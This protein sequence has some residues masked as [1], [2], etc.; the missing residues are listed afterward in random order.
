[1]FLCSY[2]LLIGQSKSALSA[3]P[4]AIGDLDC[5]RPVGPIILNP[6]EQAP[7]GES[8]WLFID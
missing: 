3:H 1:M 8:L 5:N 7:C 2:Y 6:S 4:L